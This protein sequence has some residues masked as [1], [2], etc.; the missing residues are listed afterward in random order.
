MSIGLLNTF[1]GFY[2]TVK[3]APYGGFDEDT[4]RTRIEETCARTLELPLLVRRMVYPFYFV[5][6]GG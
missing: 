6:T 4:V 1:S 2:D 3:L 5:S